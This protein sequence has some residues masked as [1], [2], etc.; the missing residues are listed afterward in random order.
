MDVQSYEQLEV[1]DETLG[2]ARNFLLENQEAVVATHEGRVLFVEMPP[3]V[4]LQISFTEPGV[5][6][7]SA[8]GRTKPA[9]LETGHQIQVPLFVDTGERV[10]VDTRDSSYLGRVK[11]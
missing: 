3:A 5:A 9:T 2:D 7:D 6:G 11:G 8:T 10:R 1:D 4:E